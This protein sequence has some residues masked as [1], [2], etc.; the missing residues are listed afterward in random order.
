METLP[1]DHDPSIAP[2]NRLPK[3][4]AHH[5]LSVQAPKQWETLT[6]WAPSYELIRIWTGP[7]LTPVDD[8]HKQCKDGGMTTTPLFS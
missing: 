8:W 6:S 7:F 2:I 3:F 5:A 1:G 4:A